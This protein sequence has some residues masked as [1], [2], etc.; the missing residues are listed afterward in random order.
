MTVYREGLGTAERHRPF[1]AGRGSGEAVH[2][3]L[4]RQANQISPFQGGLSDRSL[5]PRGRCF[6]AV[7]VSISAPLTRFGWSSLHP[8][9][10]RPAC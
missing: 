9:G 6:S 4:K 2:L 1:R 5:A 8:G 3:A 7:P 10:N